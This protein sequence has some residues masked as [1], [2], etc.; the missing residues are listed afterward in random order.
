MAQ[1]TRISAPILDTDR[2]ALLAI[3]DMGDYSP[4]NM[5]YS[6]AALQELEVA[7]TAA[8]QE[9]TRARRALDIARDRAVETSRRFHEAMLGAKA[10]VVAQYGND[11]LA[12]EAIGLTR[13]S[14]RRRPV[15]RRAMMAD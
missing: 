7:L 6:T 1:T 14:E 13:K 9:E 8:E 11:S 3:R 12:V 10:Q 15:R 5:A 2:A 4:L